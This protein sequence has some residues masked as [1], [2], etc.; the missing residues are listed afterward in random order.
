MHMVAYNEYLATHYVQAQLQECVRVR[1]PT[2]RCKS[3]KAATVVDSLMQYPSFESD[4]VRWTAKDATLGNI[5]EIGGKKIGTGFQDYDGVV[6]ED[7]ATVERKR[8]LQRDH[9]LRILR[10]GYN[11]LVQK[12]DSLAKSTSSISTSSISTQ[13]LHTTT[14][15]PPSDFFRS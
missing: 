1:A 14:Q 7:G 11:K 10:T 6:G 2:A 15:A 12:R 5:L 13:V 8:K 3:K 9:T 4:G